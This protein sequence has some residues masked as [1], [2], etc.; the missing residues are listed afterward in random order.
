[1]MYTDDVQRMVEVSVRKVASL[2]H[3]HLS[4]AEISLGSGRALMFRSRE[5]TR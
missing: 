5:E 1:M 4:P 2:P 3:E